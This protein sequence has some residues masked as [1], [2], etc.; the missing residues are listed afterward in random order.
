[1]ITLPPSYPK[2]PVNEAWNLDHR[3]FERASDRKLYQRT[4]QQDL[5]PFLHSVKLHRPA[6]S[7]NYAGIINFKSNFLYSSAYH[8]NIFIRQI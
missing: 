8:P 7:Q 4:D 3:I 5:C 6:R 1:M 2:L